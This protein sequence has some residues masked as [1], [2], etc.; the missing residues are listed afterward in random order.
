[1]ALPNPPT[2]PTSTPTPY[3]LHQYPQRHHLCQSKH[4]EEQFTLQAWNILLL[5][6]KLP[7]SRQ[8]NLTLKYW[9]HVIPPLPIKV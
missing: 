2:T 3:L 7:N 1:M 4:S 9:D 6:K 8:K 5:H